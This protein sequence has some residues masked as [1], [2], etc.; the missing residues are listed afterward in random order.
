MTMNK[1]TTLAL[2]AL[3]FG[4]CMADDVTDDVTSQESAIE[5]APAPAPEPETTTNPD[6][7][8]AISTYCRQA[9]VLSAGRCYDRCGETTSNNPDE[10]A[11]DDAC[12]EEQ[13][14]CQ[15]MCA[16]VFGHGGGPLPFGDVM[17]DEA[18]APGDGDDFSSQRRIARRVCLSYCQSDMFTGQ[19]FCRD[20][21]P[22][23]A[24]QCLNDVNEEYH[25]CQDEC[26]LI[27]VPSC[28]PHNCVG[29]NIGGIP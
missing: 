10:T 19:A 21:H 15:D 24:G 16:R 12:H 3:L 1:L 14:S 23:D 27:P 8:R 17:A 25:Q 4:G 18:P 7:L 11:C 28:Y 20:F 22:A 9:C 29:G 5:E 6:E 2:A 26:D 13:G